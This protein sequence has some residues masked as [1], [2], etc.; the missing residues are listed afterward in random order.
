[1]VLDRAGVDRGG[2]AGGILLSRPQPVDQ[3]GDLTVVGADE[4]GRQ[5]RQLDVIAAD[6]G[7][8]LAQD[9]PLALHGREVAH[10]VGR[11]GVLRR[12]SQG[13]SFASTSDDDRHRVQWSR[14]A[15][16]VREGDGATLERRIA[17]T[18]QHWQDL[19][20]VL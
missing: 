8:M 4:R 3:L 15:A 1:M 7:A 16:G 6:R 17:G 5:V 19:Q 14:V 20:G 13:A 9:V 11:V 18:P 12:Q 2:V 10:H